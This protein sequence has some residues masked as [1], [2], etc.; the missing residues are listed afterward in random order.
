[1]DK[2]QILQTNLFARQKKKLKKNQV[3][4]LDKAIQSL[5]VHPKIGQQKAGDLSEV[6]VFKFPIVKQQ[7]LLAYIWDEK[8]RTLIALGVHENFYRD[9]K[10]AVKF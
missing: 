9:I 3:A 7:Y 8:S 5:I 4:D 2:I 1:M 10:R 6:W